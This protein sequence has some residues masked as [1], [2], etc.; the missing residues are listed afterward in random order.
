MK[1][2]WLTRILTSILN[3]WN[4]LFG[5]N[6]HP[7][8]VPE[9]QKKDLHSTD[10]LLFS[11]DQ[12]NGVS[13][14]I[15]FL[16]GGKVS[17]S[18]IKDS[19]SDTLIHGLRPHV[20]EGSVT[21][22]FK[23]REIYVMRIAQDRDLQP[24]LSAATEYVKNKE[25]FPMSTLYLLG[26]I[27]LYKRFTPDGE[28]QKW[29]TLILRRVVTEIEE[30]IRQRD[31]PGKLP[32][33][34]SQFVFQCYKKGNVPLKIKNGVLL[35][36]EKEQDNY[37]RNLIE[38]ALDTPSSLHADM[39]DQVQADQATDEGLISN[40]ELANSLLKSLRS[41]RV[42]AIN[43]LS[44]ELIGEVNNFG[45]VIHEAVS[46]DTLSGLSGDSSVLAEQINS[47][48]SR[49]LEYL[50]VNEALFVTPFD[51]L[52]NCPTLKLKGVIKD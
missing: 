3:W 15:I 33:V 5:S 48:M 26:L 4:E 11:A 18:A 21:E 19:K 36:T 45:R 22:L 10:V 51:L 39:T 20:Q 35:K 1:E 8:N 40:E 23:N 7:D 37:N 6:H 13:Q 2:N 16:T 44:S 30:F 41:T 38:V 12:D 27:L 25:P 52:M 29:V 34:C 50:R 28:I 42:S 47:Y 43:T 9:I 17:H 31:Y 24:V 46:G 32:M 49:G 14:A